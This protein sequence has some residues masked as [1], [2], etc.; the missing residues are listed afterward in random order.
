MFP[1][2][3]KWGE[4]QLLQCDR[5][6]ERLE[7]SEETTKSASAQPFICRTVEQEVFLGFQLIA[8]SAESVVVVMATSVGTRDDL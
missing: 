2:E 4:E 7:Y 1:S 5:L 6:V 8:V 3:G